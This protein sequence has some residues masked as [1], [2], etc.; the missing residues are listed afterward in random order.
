[1]NITQKKENGKKKKKVQDPEL[2]TDQGLKRI[3]H[4]RTIAGSP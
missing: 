2:I 1:M 3:I 4:M